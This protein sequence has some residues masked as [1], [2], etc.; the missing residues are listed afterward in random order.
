MNRIAQMKTAEVQDDQGPLTVIMIALDVPDLRGAPGF[1]QE[2]AN[3]FKAFRML[4]S[5]DTAGLLVTVIG[6]LPAADFAKRWQELVAND[7]ILTLYMSTMRV[8][9]VIQGTAAGK[10]LSSATLLS[11]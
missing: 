3:Q 6:A 7:Q 4:N 8:A 2:V 10:V 9:D 11:V 1:I 5:P